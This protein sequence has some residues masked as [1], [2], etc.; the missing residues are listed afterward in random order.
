MIANAEISRRTLAKGAV[1]TVP[2][3]AAS[4]TA[5][6]MAASLKLDLCP[7]NAATA[8]NWLEYQQR[9]GTT[10]SWHQ[11]GPVGV[12]YWANK[13]NEDTFVANAPLEVDWTK[14]GQEG[15][16]T[17]E[18]P[19]ELLAMGI[20]WDPVTKQISG[21]I[22]PN[23]SALE[24]EIK[25]R[26]QTA[27]FTCLLPMPFKVVERPPLI[28]VTQNWGE[29]R[30]GNANIYAFH[31]TNVTDKPI[32]GRDFKAKIH[33]NFIPKQ[34]VVGPQGW[35]RVPTGGVDSPLS[36]ILGI[37]MSSYMSWAW[38]T[39]AIPLHAGQ[40]AILVESGSGIFNNLKPTGIYE[41]LRTIR[42]PSNYDSTQ[43]VASWHLTLADDAVLLPGET[44]HVQIGQPGPSTFFWMPSVE[45]DLP[46][47]TSDNSPKSLDIMN[48]APTLNNI[49][50]PR[51][52]QG[53]GGSKLERRVQTFYRGWTPFPYSTRFH[54]DWDRSEAWVK[55]NPK[56][57]PFRAF[58][59]GMFGN[60]YEMKDDLYRC[61]TEKCGDDGYVRDGRCNSIY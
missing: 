36:E 14:L 33:A 17:V 54:P 51:T 56:A 1:W 47:I 22:S 15:T 25:I 41:D 7:D 61:T 27:R 53:V 46:G 29:T 6:A 5:P 52:W 42:K 13:N 60:V 12:P 32:R 16:A 18:L 28:S 24:G 2:V 23:M 59:Q 31:I 49:I 20:K 8:V 57:L 9:S 10:P 40:K 48:Y 45:L 26:L 44:L 34:E 35:T 43:G 4:T 38:G 37:N 30:A 3:V 58:D 11:G 39:S 19:P 21:S 55:K 50:K